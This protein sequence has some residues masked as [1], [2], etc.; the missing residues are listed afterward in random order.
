MEYPYSPAQRAGTSLPVQ[1][2][3]RRSAR[4]LA[5]VREAGG[6]D[7][8]VDLAVARAQEGSRDAMRYLYCRYADAVYGYVRSIVGDEY[9][10]EDVTHSVF[11]KLITRIGSYEPRTT[12]FS[13]WLLKVARNAALDHLRQRRPVP[14]EEVRTSDERATVDR[15]FDSDGVL[16]DAMAELT[17][18]QR[19]VVFL[20]HIAGLTPPE[21]A[22]RTGFTEAAVHGLHHR[23]RL[24]L[25]RALENRGTRPCVRPRLVAEPPGAPAPAQNAI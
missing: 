14:T 24:A 25:R 5:I 20:R 11:A 21:I 3:R 16:H 19:R 4:K 8:Q 2:G 12:P 17:D 1:R 7:R 6:E 13:A 9:E 23:G 10:A 18:D 22:T 15:G